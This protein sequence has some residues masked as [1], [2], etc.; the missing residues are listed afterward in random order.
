MMARSWQRWNPPAYRAE[1]LGLLA[2]LC[3]EAVLSTTVSQE[4]IV[5]LKDRRNLGEKRMTSSNPKSLSW[6]NWMSIETVISRVFRVNS[7][8][9]CGGNSYDALVIWSDH[10]LALSSQNFYRLGLP[11]LVKPLAPP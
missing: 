4:V 11:R 9:L 6:R 3:E 2:A 5:V 8:G 1:Y 7:T 10:W